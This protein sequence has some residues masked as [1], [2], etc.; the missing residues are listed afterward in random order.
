L[1]ENFQPQ[2][3]QPKQAPFANVN[4]VLFVILSLFTVFITYQ[5]I[6]GLIS[7]LFLGI[8]G[9]TPIQNIPLTRIVI[10]FSQFMFILAPVWLLS[11]LQGNKSKTFFRLNAPK[12]NVF[13]LSVLGILV[14]Q[15]F[16]QLFIWAQDKLL[17]S[18]P[19]ISEGYHVVKD[20]FEK[21]E[22]FTLTLVSSHSVP[23]LIGVIFI[24]AV[25]PAICEEFFFRGLIMKNLEKVYSALKS[26]VLCGL[27][28]AIFHFQP[29]NLFPL[30]ILGCYLSLIVICSDSL[31]T[32]IVCHFINNFIAAISLYIYG[33]EDFTAN[34]QP[35]DEM[36][37][38]VL[39][40]ISLILFIAIIYFIIKLRHRKPE[41]P[42]FTETTET[43]V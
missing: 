7:Y 29:I 3:I 38:I 33:K 34:I 2:N 41:I 1:E 32:S 12:A 9:V 42:Q 22:E 36:S 18:I 5:I 40:L 20:T 30:I 37:L 4:P 27:L 8:D 6:G 39:G 13:A 31:Y 25:T 21:L 35:S 11:I 16:L 43:I 10:T 19:G 26:V 15:P 17:S 23:E 28:F 24:I 14:V